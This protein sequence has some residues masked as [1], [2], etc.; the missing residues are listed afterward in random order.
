MRKLMIALA[1]LGILSVCLGAAQVSPPRAMTIDDALDM[2][3]VANPQISPDGKWVLY[4]RSELKWKDNKREGRYWMVSAD[5]G[6]PF[7]FLSGENDSS[8]AWSP[9]G[10]SIAFLASREKESKDRQIYLIRANGGEAVKLTDHKDGINSFRWA[11]D[12][13]RIFFVANEPKSEEQKKAEKAGE[14]VIAV[15]E[16]PNGQRRGQWNQLWVFKLDDKKERQLTKER[17]IIGGYEPSLDASKV[18]YTYRTEN[19]RNGGNL[20]EI[21]LIEVEAGTVTRL[22]DNKAPEGDIHWSPDGRTLGFTAGSITDWDLRHAKIWLLPLDTKTPRLI[23]GSFEGNISDY[24]WVPDG[25][26]ILFHAQHRSFR[27]AYRLDLSTGS[28]APVTNVRGVLEVSSFSADRLRAAGTHSDP[29]SPT[30]VIVLDVAAGEWKKI[31]DHNPQIRNLALATSELTTWK[32]KDGL[33]IEGILHLPSDH[34]PGARLPLMLN[35]H[36]GPAG[37]FAYSFNPIH[38]IY[39]GHGFASLSPNVRGSSGYSDALLRGNRFDI[40]GGDYQDLMTGVDALIA[41]GIADP[42]QMGIRGWSYGGILGG[43]TITQTNRFKAASL[44]AMVSDWSSEFAMGFNHDVR[45]WYIGGTPWENPTKYRNMSSYTHIKNVRT[46]A[47]IIHGEEDTTDTIG[48]S[49]IY[50][51][52]LKER[53]VPVRFLRYPREPHGFREPHHQRSRD[54]EEMRWMLK[55]VLGMEWNAPDRPEDKKEEKEKAK[56]K[57]SN[58]N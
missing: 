27:N 16:G 1:L 35:V 2:I 9:D 49:M 50:Y 25:K 44:G 15:D 48:Q 36:G 42:D 19:L 31:T 47:I 8:A 22:T 45:L 24:A 13:K 39:A 14:D 26:S 21:A 58:H 30:E 3:Q 55:H 46:P 54:V 18:A 43:W 4:S 5:G 34:K 10:G 23:S 20:S 28:V 53:G 57:I 51:T 6:E 56:E 32:S 7:Q 12:G 37:V 52:G 41:R 17:I 38:H 40:G 29:S 11:K 33:E